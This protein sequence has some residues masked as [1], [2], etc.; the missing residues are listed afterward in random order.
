MQ[1]YRAEPD[2]HPAHGDTFDHPFDDALAAAYAWPDRAAQ[3]VVVRANMIGSLDGGAT[4]Q[5][6][7]AGLS[8]PADTAL[9]T[10]LQDLSDVVLVAGGTVRAE[11]YPG[12]E[13]TPP[14]AARRRRWGFDGPPPIAVITGSG[15]PPDSPLYTQTVV[16]PIVITTEQAADTVP[17]TAEVIV[18]GHTRVHLPSA[19]TAL[20]QRGLRRVHCEG[21]PSLLGQLVAGNLLDELCLTISPMLLGTGHA[22]P[23]LGGID[24]ADPASWTLAAV[25]GDGSH[26]F[27]RYIRA[28]RG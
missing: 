11:G 15:L 19:L 20:G 27:T 22:R 8:T 12:I 5:G 14:R 16:P 10:L 26:L 21:G 18:A 28:G 25:H 9:F 6:R 24:L 1:R 13:L 23:L 7:S 2:D 3:R 4:V 17:D